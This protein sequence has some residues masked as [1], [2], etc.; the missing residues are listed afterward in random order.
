[1]L[2]IKYVHTAILQ[3]LSKFEEIRLVR[4][5]HNKFEHTYRVSNYKNLLLIIIIHVW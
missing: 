2:R 1:M 3:I 5:N 4:F